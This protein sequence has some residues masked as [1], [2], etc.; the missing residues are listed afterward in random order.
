MVP[1]PISKPPSLGNR[2]IQL[3]LL[4]L[5]FQVTQDLVHAFHFGITCMVLTLIRLV[6]TQSLEVRLDQLFGR[7]KEIKLI[8]GS[9]AKCF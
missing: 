7:K 1:M 6:S 2:M 5:K 9:T 3:D 8:C 4:V